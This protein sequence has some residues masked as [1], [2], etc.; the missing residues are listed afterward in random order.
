MNTDNT[1][2]YEVQ[3]VAAGT[4]AL[5]EV[6]AAIPVALDVP[7]EPQASAPLDK[8]DLPT[9]APDAFA[10]RAGVVVTGGATDPVYLDKCVFKNAGA[11]K[12]LSVHHLQRRLVELGY[13]N[14]LGDPDGW[15]GDDTRACVHA[16]Q[17]DSNIDGDGIMDATT[18]EAL[19][20]RDP[21]V[22]VVLVN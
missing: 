2:E 10:K 9:P 7:A 3:A 13:H 22:T 1:E 6:L 11:R 16:F 8:F 14:A 5:V 20:A 4:E 15:Y 17:K 12:S 21:H 19:F 18:L